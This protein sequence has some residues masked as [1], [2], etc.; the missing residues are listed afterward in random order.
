MTAEAIFVA[1]TLAWFAMAEVVG[2]PV[3]YALRLWLGPHAGR[4]IFSI[5]TFK[6]AIERLVVLVGLLSGFPQILI[7]FGALKIANR[8]ADEDNN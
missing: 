5:E 7:A 1:N 8:L 4:Y 6:G 3:F 2:L